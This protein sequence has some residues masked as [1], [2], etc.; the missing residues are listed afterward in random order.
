MNVLLIS[1]YKPDAQQSM[2]RYAEMLRQQFTERGCS[3]TVANPRV[4]FGNSFLA[5]G[6]FKKWLGYVDKYLLAPR[7]LRKLAGH[8]D[9]VHICDHSNAVYL[10]C[11]KGKPALVT[12]HDVLAILSARNKFSGIHTGATGR[13]LQRWIASWLTR[14]NYVV[15]VSEKTRQDLLSLSPHSNAVT[16]IIHHPLNW[17]Y[18]PVENHRIAQTK[19]VNGI[20]TNEEYLIHVGGNQWYKNRLGA[21]QIFAALRKIERFQQVKLVMAGK[22]WTPEMYRY[23]SDAKLD[24]A[25]LERVDISNEDLQALYSGAL[26]LLFPSREEGFGWPILEAQA[27]GCPVITSNRP[28]MTEIAGDAAVF[29]DPDAPQLA[30]QIIAAQVENFPNL[31]VGGFGNL[32]RFSME[33]AIDQ[34]LAV[35]EEVLLGSES[36]DEKKP[37]HSGQNQHH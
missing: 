20:G 26:A 28:P 31:R 11:A 29:I 13:I 27:C 37:G 5:R 21:M 25:I 30:A 18:A 14:A 10:P 16:C 33:K 9:I 4:V 22:P 17:S 19:Q 34:Y 15:C 36:L 2:L 23:R 6:P 35:Y 1:N 8:A 3:V 24:D 32:A 7:Q 12:C